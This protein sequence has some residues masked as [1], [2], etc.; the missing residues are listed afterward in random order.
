M[1]VWL[2]PERLAK[3]GLN[4]R[5]RDRRGARAERCR[6]PPARSASRPRRR[7]PAV[8]VPLRTQGPPHHGRGVREDRGPRASRTARCCA[9]RTSARVELGAESYG[10]FSRGSGAAPRR[11][12]ASTQLPTRERAR[13]REGGAR[14]AGAARRRASRPAS[15]TQIALRHDALRRRVDPRGAHDARRGDA[16]S[17][18]SSSTCSSRACARR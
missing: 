14:R 2:D 15:S 11:R 13:R 4:A 18:S 10:G 5:R 6:S 12:S 8:P 9:R 3:L 17:S 1:R 7:G 16:C